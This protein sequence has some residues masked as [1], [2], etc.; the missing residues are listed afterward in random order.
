[1]LAHGGDMLTYTIAVTLTGNSLSGIVVTDT[2]PVG[3]SFSDF[4]SNPYGITGGFNAA[5]D[6]L[7]WSLPS[8]LAPGV[9]QF[10]YQTRVNDFVEANSPLLNRAEL[11][12]P[13]QTSSLVSSVP[14]TVIGNYTVNVNVYNSAGEIVKTILLK[15]FTQPITNVQLLSSDLISTLQGAGSEIDLVYNGTVISIWDGTNGANDPVTNGKYHL[16]I[17]SISDTGVVTSVSQEVMVSRK[18]ATITVKVYNGAGEVV[19]TLYNVVDDPV[20]ASMMGVDLSAAVIKPGT[21]AT[22]TVPSQERVIIQ[23]SGTPVTLLWDGTND[24]GTYVTSGNYQ[25]EVHWNDGAGQ[26]T[27]IT[28]Q[29]MVMAGS[30]TTGL[31]IARPNVLNAAHG[32]TTTFDATAVSG[33]YAIK[34]SVYALSGELVEVLQSAPGTLTV[35]WDATGKASGLYIAVV[36]VQTPQGGT[37]SVQRMKVLI[38]R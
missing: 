29:M 24:A 15:Q 14:V 8:P 7:Q 18:L 3:V 22:G 12:Y 34:T 19:R 35:D 5:T 6:Q 23:T 28:K 33:A 30:G 27:D 17:D 36:E 26:T 11:T 32:M 21:A 25:I 1:M 2:L 4:M 20:G 9:Y 10:S 16:Q 37:V 38:L 31:V 13:G